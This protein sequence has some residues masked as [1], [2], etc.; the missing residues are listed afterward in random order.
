METL[1]LLGAGASAGK[2]NNYLSEN[3]EYI[4][5][6]SN[7]QIRL[8]S[9]LS[10]IQSLAEDKDSVWS[11]I[12]KS[13]IDD[14]ILLH[15]GIVNMGT[16]DIFAKSLYLQGNKKDYTSVKRALSFYLTYLQLKENLL[17]TIDPRYIGFFSATIE[18][19]THKPVQL[20]PDIKIATWNYDL[21]I[22]LSL[23]V[24]LNMDLPR[25]H[26]YIS[27]M[28]HLKLSQSENPGKIFRLNGYAGSYLFGNQINGCY[29]EDIF[30]QNKNLNDKI[31]KLIEI[32]DELRAKGDPFLNF[33]WDTDPIIIQERNKFFES[34]Q[35]VK[36]I[37]VIG[38]SFPTF[39]RFIDRELFQSCKSLEK[40]YV[41]DTNPDIVKRVRGIYGNSKIINQ[42]IPEIQHVS[43]IGQF[44]IPPELDQ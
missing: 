8:K 44:F 23:S 14:L 20:H 11:K 31:A 29:L 17:E 37:V 40:V 25:V 3:E 10:R 38:Y 41:L 4:P 1:Y 2:I 15:N 16:P 6:V 7:F 22:P 28:Y 43:D 24:L 36:V 19:K 18:K 27:D 33:A 21:Q 9:D 5:T 26:D 35:N 42:F 34:L 39:N 12:S 32:F 13:L 30:D